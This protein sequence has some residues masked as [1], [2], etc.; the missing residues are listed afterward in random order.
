ME[1][2]G[3]LEK[4]KRGK[5]WE[6][7]PTVYAERFVRFLNDNGVRGKVVDIGCGN[8]RDV[9]VFKNAGFDALGIDHSPEEIRHASMLHP[10]CMFEVQNAES[11]NLQDNSVAAFFMINVVHYTRKKEAF[12]EIQR[13]LMPG[14]LVLVHF[15]LSIVDSYLNVDYRDDEKE[16]MSLV[17]DFEVM[18]R[19]TFQRKD[20][21]PHEHTHTILELILKKK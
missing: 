19:E 16:I 7:H 5:H 1:N 15:N 2:P 11:M 18:H 8:G 4:Y 13:A 17:S 3:L 10:D 20:M 9:A 6:K 12:R 14:G 21:L